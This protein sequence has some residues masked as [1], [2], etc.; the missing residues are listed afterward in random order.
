MADA[1][2]AIEMS[3]LDRRLLEVSQALQSAVSWG[4]AHREDSEAVKKT[5]LDCRELLDQVMDATILSW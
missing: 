1:T 2:L 3:T 5:T 4:M